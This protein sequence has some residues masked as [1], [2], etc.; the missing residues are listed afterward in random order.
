MRQHSKKYNQLHTYFS[1]C[2][3]TTVRIIVMRTNVRKVGCK[4]DKDYGH[5]VEVERYL[6]IK[7]VLSYDF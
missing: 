2:M 6:A 3:G 7:Q 1:P 5:L 4:M